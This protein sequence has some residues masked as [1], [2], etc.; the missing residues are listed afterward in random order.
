MRIGI[1]SIITSLCFCSF[2]VTIFCILSGSEKFIYHINIKCSLFFLSCLVI[3]LLLPIEFM[4][5]HSLYFKSFFTS[6][7]AFL[8]FKLNIYFFSFKIYHLLLF[9]WGSGAFIIGLHKIRHYFN[10]RSYIKLIG[11]SIPNRDD[12][13]GFSFTTFFKDH[14]KFRNIHIL[15]CSELPGPTIIGLKN[16]LLILPDI[17]YDSY[18]LQ[19]ILQHEAIHL[20]HNDVFWKLL[21][22]FVCTVFWWNPIFYVFQHHLFDLM[23]LNVDSVLA[24]NMD[25]TQRIRYLSCMMRMLKLSH[26]CDTI[27]SVYFTRNTFEAFRLRFKCI[28]RDFHEKKSVTVFSYI[29]ILGIFLSSLLVIFEPVFP[30]PEDD[31]MI[32]FSQMYAVY[33]DGVYDIYA[34]ET[35]LL[36]E[37]SLDLYPEEMEVY[38][39]K[40]GGI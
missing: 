9:I 37:H 8:D 13:Y 14:P 34:N 30:M 22:S 5:T 39:E 19:L 20:Q 28:C 35:Y 31:N 21:V 7:R 25:N 10:I 3:R 40:N 29:I 12:F 23:E 24:K 4:F 36:S 17:T 6:I 18:E 2:Y 11:R 33:H 38:D 32:S 16:R 1:S 15:L 26:S 27:G